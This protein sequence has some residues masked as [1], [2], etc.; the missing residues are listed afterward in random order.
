MVYMN[1]TPCGPVWHQEYEGEWPE[2][3][4]H[5]S[6]DHSYR[7][8]E[9]LYHNCQGDLRR[10]LDA[11][12]HAFREKVVEKEHLEKLVDSYREMGLSSKT[13]DLEKAQEDYM[14]MTHMIHTQMGVPA[15]MLNQSQVFGYVMEADVN[16]LVK[17]VPGIVGDCDCVGNSIEK[18]AEETK[19]SE[20]LYKDIKDTKS[21]NGGK[22]TCSE[23][24]W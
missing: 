8:I 20:L 12:A 7:H 13:I 10:F 15:S 3:S 22:K 14:R 19:C 2:E 24:L 9:K 11:I 23:L 16:G 17:V 4:K 5:S 6:I 18:K 21:K 1:P